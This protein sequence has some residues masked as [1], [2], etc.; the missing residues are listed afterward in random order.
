LG[1]KGQQFEP[2]TSVRLWKQPVISGVILWI[3]GSATKLY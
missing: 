3:I 2:R 1:V